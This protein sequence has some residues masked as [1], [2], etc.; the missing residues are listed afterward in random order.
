DS[1]ADVAILEDS[2]SRCHRHSSLVD[3]F[4]D[5]KCREWEVSIHH[6]FREANHAADFMANLGHNLDLGTHVFQVPVNS[7]LYWLRHD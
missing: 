4:H 3:Q 5:L 7:L 1:R 2:A 6:I